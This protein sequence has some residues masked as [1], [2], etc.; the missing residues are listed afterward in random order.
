MRSGKCMDYPLNNLFSAGVIP[1]QSLYQII[2]V[3]LWTWQVTCKGQRLNAHRPH[4]SSGHS[5]ANHFMM[6]RMGPYN[7][8]G[9]DR[10]WLGYTFSLLWI[11]FTT[12]SMGIMLSCWAWL[13]E[14]WRCS[15]YSVS[16]G[17]SVALGREQMGDRCVGQEKKS[18][19][20]T[21]KAGIYFKNLI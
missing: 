12:H 21:K 14:G 13:W 18:K 19:W 3:L 16:H 6:G 8:D 5:L 9:I 4:G 2:A 7:A 1:Q 20:N 11:S 17:P 15:R 10:P